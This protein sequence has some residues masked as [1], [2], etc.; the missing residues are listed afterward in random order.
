MQGLY[1]HLSP[2][3]IEWNSL[4]YVWCLWY[5]DTNHYIHDIDENNCSKLRNIW[6]NNPVIGFSPNVA[7]IYNSMLVV[8]YCCFVLHGQA[9]PSAPIT[10]WRHQME[11]VS[12]LLP[13]CVGNS[14]VTGEY[15]SQRPVMQSF[16]C[17]LWSVPKKDH[18]S[19]NI[20]RIYQLLSNI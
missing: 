1:T 3:L 11:I 12:A 4:P 9:F 5:V 20:E 17:P 18:A 2:S 15:P 6:L 14:L 7:K 16:W 13:L 19:W 10:W 8:I